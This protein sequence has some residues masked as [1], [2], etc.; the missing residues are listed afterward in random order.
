LVRPPRAKC[1]ARWNSPS[2]V[3]LP[4]RLVRQ[5]TVPQQEE[6]VLTPI[7]VAA[8]LPKAEGR[9]RPL[10]VA[11]LEVKIVQQAV[12]TV[13]TRFTRST[14]GASPTGFVRDAVRIRRSMRL[15]WDWSGRR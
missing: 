9:Q 12:V 3:A 4:I 5:S 14:S 1:F 11:A 8:L 7:E 10:G 6:I 2:G 15:P 13:L